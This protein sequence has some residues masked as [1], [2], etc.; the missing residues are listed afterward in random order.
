[1]RSCSTRNKV[2]VQ[3]GLRGTKRIGQDPDTSDS[4]CMLQKADDGHSRRLKLDVAVGHGKPQ[5]IQVK[6][7]YAPRAGSLLGRLT[8]HFP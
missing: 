2:N 1:M 6:S 5:V 8:S 7:S 3:T 4:Q